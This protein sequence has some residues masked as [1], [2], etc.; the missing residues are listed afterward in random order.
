M[1]HRNHA[2]LEMAIVLSAPLLSLSIF[3]L[4]NYKQWSPTQ[5]DR[6][7]TMIIT[8][9]AMVAVPT[10]LFAIVQQRKGNR[11]DAGVY[12]NPLEADRHGS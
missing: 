2:L 11:S 7:S 10:L 8:A 1:S 9:Y 3:V 4:I 12:S 6:P 5:S